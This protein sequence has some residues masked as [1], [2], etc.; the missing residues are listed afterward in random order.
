MRRDL[1]TEDHEAFRGLARDFVEKEVVPH[2]PEWEKGGRMPREV[3][4]QM[5]SLGMLGMA[6]PE[7]YGGGGTP[8]YR[9]NV[10]HAGGGG[11][12]AGD[13][14]D[15]AHPAR[16]DPAVLPALR[17]RGAAQALVPRPRRGHAADR[18]RDDRTGHRIRSGRHAHHR[19]A[20]RGR[21]DRQ[22]RQDIHHRRH[23]GRPG[24]RGGAHLDGSGQPPQ[25]PDAVR[26]RGRHG[27]A[28]PAAASWRRWAARCR[29]PPSCRSSTCASRRP[30]CSA[31][32]AR[33]SATSATTCRRSG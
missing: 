16:G 26:R 1:F 22:R 9:Y 11:A 31:R 27:R 33:R 4:K 28:S 14:V 17:E 5:G 7:E 23:A 24:D 18:R 12:G 30:T 6:I 13:A 19:G 3:F 2:Y 21:L 8:D 29:T 15:G 20:R 10:V 32:R 25:G